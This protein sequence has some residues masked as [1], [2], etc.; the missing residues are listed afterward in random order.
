[1]PGQRGISG[2]SRPPRHRSLLRGYGHPRPRRPPWRRM[3]SG[4]LPS[5]HPPHGS[6]RLPATNRP[7]RRALLRLLRRS[8]PRRPGPP[9]RLGGRRCV[10]RRRR[11]PRLGL[12]EGGRLPH[13]PQLA[14]LRTHLL[15]PLPRVH[16][17]PHRHRSSREN[18]RPAATPAPAPVQPPR[19]APRPRRLRPV[20]L[21]RATRHPAQLTAMAPSASASSTSLEG[22]VALVTGGSRGLGREMILAFAEAGAD[23]IIASR[24][25]E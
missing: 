13:A 3:G 11:Q 22:K 16:P 12:V 8:R 19:P 18:R 25:K 9:P 20:P 4:R 6:P 1:R 5:R 14:A 23:V 24:K 10:G 21:W 7:V 15:R 2:P 17:I